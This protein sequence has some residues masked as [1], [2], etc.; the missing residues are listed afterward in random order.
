MLK[1][2][3]S[4]VEWAPSSHQVPS[5]L[6]QQKPERLLLHI[7]VKREWWDQ[8]LWVL[9]WDS[10]N[11]ELQRCTSLI[12]SLATPCDKGVAAEGSYVCMIWQFEPVTPH[13]PSEQSSHHLSCLYHFTPSASV[14]HAKIWET[15]KD[16]NACKSVSRIQLKAMTNASSEILF[17]WANNLNLVS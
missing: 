4:V 10:L 9:S 3:Y 14:W 7:L 8:E 12:F 13:L 2:D 11:V 17:C 16:A 1:V 6:E 5:K 15:N